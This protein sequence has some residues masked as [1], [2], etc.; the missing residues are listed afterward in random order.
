MGPA[1]QAMSAEAD[2]ARRYGAGEEGF[3]MNYLPGDMK[4]AE[5]GVKKVAGLTN[6]SSGRS[7][8]GSQRSLDLGD[9]ERG[10]FG[11]RDFL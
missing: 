9:V 10:G 11:N 7:A 4:S 2:R 3:A 1:A 6:G 5:K 8:S